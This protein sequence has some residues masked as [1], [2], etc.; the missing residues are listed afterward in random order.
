MS[1]KQTIGQLAKS[2]EINIETIRFYE[3]KG[4]INQPQ[5]PISGFRVYSDDI[6]E[7][8]AFIRRSQ[9]LGFTLDEISH[10]LELN[11]KPCHQVQELATQKLSTISQKIVELKNLESALQSLLKQC[12]T[13]QDQNNCPI[14]ESLR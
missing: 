9:K 4:L 3:R 13:N 12:A 2:L 14:I 6:A 8:I 10:L 5:K 11:D 7:R 1:N